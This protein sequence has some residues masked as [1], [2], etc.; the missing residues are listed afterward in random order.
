MEE[1]RDEESSVCLINLNERTRYRNIRRNMRQYRKLNTE[2][3][4]AN[5]HSTSEVFGQK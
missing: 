2:K 5:E 4:G 3:N 1:F